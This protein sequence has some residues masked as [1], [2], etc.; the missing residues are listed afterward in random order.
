VS[1]A[2][3]L[4][5]FRAPSHSLRCLCRYHS[6][7]GGILLAFSGAQLAADAASSSLTTGEP[8][9]RIVE[10]LPVVHVRVSA[11][12]LL[13][14]PSP[15]AVLTARIASMGSDS[16]NCLIGGTFNCTLHKEEL[17]GGYA[18]DDASSTWRATEAH[19]AAVAAA[20]AALATE[21]A[22]AP[23]EG[24]P[25]KK[26]K[27]AE[28]YGD[29]GAAF[30]RLLACNPP[31]L[32]VGDTVT[33]RVKG[34]SLQGAAII[35]IA[36]LEDDHA[37]RTRPAGSGGEDAVAEGAGGGSSAAAVPDAPTLEHKRSKRERRAEEGV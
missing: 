15:G 35:A 24:K 17:A 12:V 16:L 11:H 28:A 5:S 1:A 22:V 20:V 30:N 27:R 8:L 23:A 3:A 13:Y 7:L 14:R 37:A 26:R 9:A 33:V 19:G 6:G 31:V 21:P 29:V 18:F 25:G 4:P 36:T 2:S 10:F 32:G 34:R